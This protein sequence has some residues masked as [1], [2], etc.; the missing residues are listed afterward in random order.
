MTEIHIGRF[1]IPLTELMKQNHPQKLVNSS[2][3]SKSNIKTT[4]NT[5][6]LIN[7]HHTRTVPKIS[8]LN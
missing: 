1:P 6:H 3:P 5:S 2:P 7:L 8:A 4:K